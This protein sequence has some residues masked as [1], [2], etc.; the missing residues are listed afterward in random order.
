MAT[1]TIG[2]QSAHDAA[3]R[4]AGQIYQQHGRSSWLNPDG[5]KNKSWS[6]RYIDVIVPSSAEQNSA[7]VIEVETDDSVSDAEARE[8]WRDYDQ[9]Y[10]Q[11]WHLAV[12]ARSADRAKGLLTKYDIQHCTVITWTQNADGTHTFWGLPGLK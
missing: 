10:Q 3:V 7:W 2:T 11:R 6:G 5:E 9:A 4:A 12:P 1:R 8:Q